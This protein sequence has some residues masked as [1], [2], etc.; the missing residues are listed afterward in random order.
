MN[1]TISGP[2]LYLSLSRNTLSG[3]LP[4]LYGASNLK[5][6]S[7]AYNKF[8][9]TIP[10]NW[11][12]LT[13]LETLELEGLSDITG[14]IPSLL[15]SWT[16]LKSLYLKETSISGKLS[17]ILENLKALGTTEKFAVFPSI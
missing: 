14:S 3:S 16:A 11:D 9:G 17:D 13:N 7:F 8:S 4:D 5:I 12:Q 10:T 2:L 6:V 15:P 1:Q